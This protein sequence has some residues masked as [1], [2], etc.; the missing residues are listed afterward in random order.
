MKIVIDELFATAHQKT[1][2]F[3]SKLPNQ[4]KPC[5]DC[6][7][8]TD[9]RKGWLGADRMKQILAEH[10][11]VCHKN[12]ALQ[13]AGHMILNKDNNSYVRVAER[14]GIALNLQGHELIFKTK[15]ECINHHNHNAK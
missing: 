3:M 7:F 13:C 11:F 10:S 4:I 12:T 8:R 14:L 9:T 2:K 1:E 15:T 6:P 5:K